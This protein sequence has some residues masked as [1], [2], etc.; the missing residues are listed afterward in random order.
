MII[1]IIKR[2]TLEKK[3]EIFYTRGRG[4]SMETIKKM[5]PTKILLVIGLMLT[6]VG[7]SIIEEKNRAAALAVL[8][9]SYTVDS[10]ASALL[11]NTFGGAVLPNNTK[12]T[13]THL[14][15]NIEDIHFSYLE[16]KDGWI[17]YKVTSGATIKYTAFAT[18][19]TGNIGMEDNSF[20]DHPAD[21][22][23]PVGLAYRFLNK[24]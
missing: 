6:L 9:G 5:I 7:C 22:A 4:A 13:I 12:L 11:H 17:I 19:T 14:E 8:K 23:P 2:V 21:I 3:P 24:Q 10:P 16:L 20:R 15:F 1:G 18:D